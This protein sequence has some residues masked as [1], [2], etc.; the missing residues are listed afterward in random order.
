MNCKSDHL[1]TQAPIPSS[2]SVARAPLLAGAATLAC[3]AA[4][5]ALGHHSYAMFD[6]TQSMFVEGTVAKVGRRWGLTIQDQVVCVSRINV[7]R[8]FPHNE[9]TGTSDMLA[10]ANPETDRKACRVGESQVNAIGNPERIVESIEVERCRINTKPVF[11][12]NG[13]EYCC[14]MLTSTTICTILAEEPF[15][16][17]SISCYLSTCLFVAQRE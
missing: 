14:M 7:F 3:V 1:P 16:N 9:R 2:T 5:P 12:Q 11:H 6:T 15:C 4:S 17:Q 13:P 10:D 8:P